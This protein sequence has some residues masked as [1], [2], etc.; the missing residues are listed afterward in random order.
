MPQSYQIIHIH[1]RCK[2]NDIRVY[3]QH[4]QVTKKIR[5]GT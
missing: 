5:N 2:I 1:L 3:T 4:E